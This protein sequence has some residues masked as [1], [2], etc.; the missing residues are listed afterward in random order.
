MAALLIDLCRLIRDNPPDKVV[1][2]KERTLTRPKIL[3]YGLPLGLLLVLLPGLSGF[4]YLQTSARPL[5]V[6]I[7]SDCSVSPDE[8]QA[9]IDQDVVWNPP[10]KT[11]QYSADFASRSP[12]AANSV[13]GGSPRT[14]Q[15]TPSCDRVSVYVRWRTKACYFPY[16][17][18]KDGKTCGDPGVRVVPPTGNLVLVY[19]MVL[20]LLGISFYFVLRILV[21]NR[22][23]PLK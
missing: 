19:G 22:T 10:D 8:R 5:P 4:T 14:I 21:R 17:V 3:G 11:H 16:S 12:F 6:D 2:H 18:L 1:L 9:S 15:A 23:S 7:G 20:G 13:S